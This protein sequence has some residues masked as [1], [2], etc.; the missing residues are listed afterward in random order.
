MI[1]RVNNIIIHGANA[2][3]GDCQLTVYKVFHKIDEKETL[4]LNHSHFYYECHLI[5][6]GVGTSMVC[7]QPLQLHEGDMFILPPQIEH[8]P[9][10]GDAQELVLALTL[11]KTGENDEYFTYFYNTLL[12]YSAVPISLPK[13]LQ[14]CFTELFYRFDSE[15]FRDRFLQQMEIYRFIYSFFDHLNRRKASTAVEKVCPSAKKD[16]MLEFMIND[17]SYSLPNI[18]EK[19]GYTSR[20]TARLIR[21]KYGMSLGEIRQKDMVT[22]AKELLHRK[23]P[24]TLQDIAIQCGFSGIKALNRTFLRHEGISPAEYRKRIREHQ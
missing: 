3:F 22:T 20:H 9:L 5:I 24:L 12:Q 6:S 10:I 11:E 14:Q 23:P 17:I 13:S 18:A 15:L 1:K 8:R 16:L 7:G 4:L 19:L 21:K 2:F